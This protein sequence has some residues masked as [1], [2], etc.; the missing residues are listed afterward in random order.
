MECAFL[1]TMYINIWFGRIFNMILFIAF[2]A[3]LRN[4]FMFFVG[5]KE[6]KWSMICSVVV[7]F[8]LVLLFGEGFVTSLKAGT[9][10][11]AMWVMMAVSPII[12]PVVFLL[13]TAGLFRVWPSPLHLHRHGRLTL[14]PVKCT[15]CDPAELQQPRAQACLSVSKISSA[16]EVQPGKGCPRS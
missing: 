11:S 4:R 6:L 15:C 3:N 14:C 10:A 2:V 1:V 9:D 13:G 8:M 16:F 5:C 7:A 12:W